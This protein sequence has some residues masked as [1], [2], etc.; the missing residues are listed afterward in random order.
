MNNIS[1]IFIQNTQQGLFSFE[2]I[3][4]GWLVS[5]NYNEFVYLKDTYIDTTYRIIILLYL[6][7]SYCSYANIIFVYLHT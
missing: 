3:F 6:L 4:V 7:Y 2:I 5:T 1:C